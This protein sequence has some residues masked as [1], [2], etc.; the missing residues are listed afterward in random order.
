MQN[1]CM[2]TWRAD[3]FM[4]FGMYQALLLEITYDNMQSF[5]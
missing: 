1:Q 2:C 4:V 3:V 5:I